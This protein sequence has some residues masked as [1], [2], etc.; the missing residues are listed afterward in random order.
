MWRLF[1]FVL[2]A[3]LLYPVASR[4][5]WHGGGESPSRS[6]TDT[7]A[8]EKIRSS[9]GKK[10]NPKGAIPSAGFRAIYFDRRNPGTAV[11]QENVESVAIKYAWSEFHDIPSQS[12]AAYWV[13]RLHFP[14]SGSRQIS[15]SQSWA[16]ARILIDGQ[17]VFD[18]G[19]N[20]SFEHHFSAG[21][22]IVEVEYIN[23]WH[24]VEFK[25]TIGEPVT[26]LSE[27]ELPGFFLQNVGTSPRLYYVGLYESAAKD[28]SVHVT[29][30]RTGGPVVLW[31]SSYEAIDWTITSP[32]RISAVVTSS[33]S[34]GSRVRGAGDA[35]VVAV[36]DWPRVH[37]ET[38][39]CSCSASG[40]FHCEDREHLG[41]AARKLEAATG[42][43]LAG[44]AVDYSADLLTMKPY[45][46][47]VAERIEAQEQANEAAR[48]QCQAAADPD[49]DTLMDQ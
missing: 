44:Y 25:V 11:F 14:E 3:A 22:H 43:D 48:K 36:R 10:L 12:F 13:G 26:E 37:S 19:S 39:R 41:G 40:H 16:K 8:P 2:A 30:P 49:F 5:I 24:T 46:R 1:L 9:W 38:R 32:D 17:I 23:N 29:L 34:P 20:K 15:V 6:V 47:G 7:Y 45:D 27:E 35:R 21:E 18:E 31:L 42:L 4:A 33:Y 28:T